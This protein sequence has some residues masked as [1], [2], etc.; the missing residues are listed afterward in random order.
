MS[1][2]PLAAGEIGITVNDPSGKRNGYMAEVME[3]NV[4]CSN[5]RIYYTVKVF[6]VSSSYV[7]GY[8]GLGV[9]DLR[10]ITD[11]DAEQTTEQEKV[12]VA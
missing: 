11:P 7:N 4:K 1:E 10:R 2:R 6:G 5:P 12:V 3:A 9:N 8:W